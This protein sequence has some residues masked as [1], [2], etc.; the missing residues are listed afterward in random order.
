MQCQWR[1]IALV[2]KAGKRARVTKASTRVTQRAIAVTTREKA[3]R[4]PKEKMAASHFQKATRVEKANR[5]SPKDKE[6]QIRATSN[7]SSVAKLDTTPRTV[8]LR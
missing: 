8:G 6:S 3:S 5:M 4:N 7:V 1:L 2:R